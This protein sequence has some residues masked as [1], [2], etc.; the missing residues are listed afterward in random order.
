MCDEV[1]RLRPAV[2][3]GCRQ[4]L[5]T[6]RG[7]FER[8][9]RR[10]APDD[11]HRARPFKEI[12]ATRRGDRDHPDEAGVEAIVQ[13][14]SIDAGVGDR[15]AHLR[16]ADFFDAARHPPQIT[17]GATRVEDPPTQDGDRFR[18]AGELALHGVAVE[19]VLDCEYLGRGTVET[20]RG[21]GRRVQTTI[22]FGLF[23]RF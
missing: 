19:I 18:V 14:A 20:F 11:D 16:S 9:A 7:A 12:A 2:N 3:Q 17:F 4:R 13:T 23:R 21:S 1:T 10:Q 8:R 6:R 15:G 22:T 5:A